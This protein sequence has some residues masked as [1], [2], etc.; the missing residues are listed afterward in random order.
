MILTEIK[1]LRVAEN[2]F[3]WCDGQTGLPEVIEGARPRIQT[4]IADMF[5]NSKVRDAEGSPARAGATSWYESPGRLFSFEVW[6]MRIS[7]LFPSKH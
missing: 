1:N 7:P 6:S 3:L 4:R 2:L 5:G